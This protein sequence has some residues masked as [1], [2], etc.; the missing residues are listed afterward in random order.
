[1]ALPLEGLQVLELTAEGSEY[2]R[3]CNGQ[4][5]GRDPQPL[6]EF[7][8]VQGVFHIVGD[9]RVLVLLKPPL[10]GHAGTE[11]PGLEQVKSNDLHQRSQGAARRLLPVRGVS[12]DSFR[13]HLLELVNRFVG[14]AAESTDQA[15]RFAS[16]Q[17]EPAGWYCLSSAGICRNPLWR[18]GTGQK[19]PRRA[20]LGEMGRFQ[21]FWLRRSRC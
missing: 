9:A 16:I 1:M 17:I 14:H 7:Y 15:A 4:L 8:R 2:L 3:R 20:F 18:A 12:E 11:A 13:Q 5:G 21:G 6:D 19:G 10:D